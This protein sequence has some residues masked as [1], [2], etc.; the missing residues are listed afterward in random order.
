MT[1]RTAGEREPR[2]ATATSASVVLA[3][4][5]VALVGVGVSVDAVDLAVVGLVAG[6]TLAVAS[7]LCNRSGPVATAAGSVAVAVGVLGTASV[8]S[9]PIVDGSVPVAAGGAVLAVAALATGLGAVATVP[10]SLGS[11]QWWRTVERAL[12]ATLLPLLVVAWAAVDA[13][14]GVGEFLNLVAGEV[15]TGVAVVLF[16]V[17]QN[18][19]VGGFLVL[20]ALAAGGVAVAAAAVP[21][22]SMAPSDRRGAVAAAVARTRRVAGRTS[23]GAAL[24]GFAATAAPTDVLHGTL[25]AV[26]VEPL[27]RAVVDVHALRVL[28]AVVAVVA[29][30]TAVAAGAVRRLARVDPRAVV[31]AVATTAPGGIVLV[32]VAVV[33]P[34]AVLSRLRIGPATVAVDAGVDVAGAVPLSAGVLLVGLVATAAALSLLSTAA[35]SGVVPDRTAAPTVA[36]AGVLLAAVATGLWPGDH[37]LVAFGAVAAAMTVW[38]VGSYG[39]GVTAEVDGTTSRLMELLHAAGTVVVGVVLVGAGSVALWAARTLATGGA[40]DGPGTVGLVLLVLATL[41]LMSTLRG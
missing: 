12:A 6:G 15:A 23:A 36:A 38:D 19:N 4:S 8:V 18:A 22:A 37:P 21:L 41:A 34:D 27:L 16:P 26:G 5:A 20:T 30:G 14:D 17:G 1:P 24:I 11:G 10:G 35:G 7:W 40:L 9:R 33:A 13:V 32:G 29:L 25:A 3:V 39:V 31:R 2:A 28:L